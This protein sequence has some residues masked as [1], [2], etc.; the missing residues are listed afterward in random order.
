MLKELW[1]SARSLAWTPGPSLALLLTIG[2]GVG[3]NASIDGF[4]RGLTTVDLP[5][6]DL[7]TLV[8]L[9]SLDAHHSAGPL[10]FDD[11]LS[12]DNPDAPFAQLGA[13]RESQQNVTL[14][15][16][17]VPM[18]VA[19]ITPDVAN[20]LGL[21]LDD[22]AAISAR[23]WEAEAGSV[24]VYDRTIRIGGAETQVKSVAPAWLDGLY[25]SRP[26]DVWVPLR[27]TTLHA[28][29]RHS[30]NFWVLARLRPG[31]SAE[32]AQSVVNANR[33]PNNTIA[34]LPYRRMT[35][36]VAEGLSR[37]ATLLRAAAGALFF[38]TCANVASFVLARASTR[39]RDTAVRVALGAGRVHLTRQLLSDSVVI[40]VAGGALGIII[41]LW[42]RDIVPWL[43]FVEDAER[44]VFAPDAA[45]ILI[46]S[47]AGIAM[48]IVCGLAPMFD[49]RADK[50][51]AVLQ[52]E[53]AGDSPRMRLFRDVLLSMQ[54]ACCCL[55]IVSTGLLIDGLRRALETREGRRL[56]EVV[57]VTPRAPAFVS[58]YETAD[59]G[60]KYFEQVE[61]AAA[62]VGDVMQTAWVGTLPGSR[63][64]WQSIRVEPPWLPLRDVVLNTEPFTARSLA[65]VKTPPVAGQMFGGFATEGCPSVVVDEQA[66]AAL[67]DDDAV[68]RI[69][70]D[71]SGQRNQIIGVV[72]PLENEQ[73][74]RRTPATVYYDGEQPGADRPS[75]SGALSRPRTADAG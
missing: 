20:L 69:V 42:T 32:Q 56:G 14:L 65:R 7:D 43:F 33:S 54:M 22:G 50:P 52:R 29:D 25:V 49:L 58:H 60:L 48:T 74:T 8:S 11:Y 75:R 31:I 17:T 71:E 39:S 23:V 38:M 36:D 18:S 40:S 28:V 13:V 2:L 30:R 21:S 16:R 27:E 73:E 68:G 45:R 67:F 34:A 46:V 62:S 5:L 9:Y 12:L 66:A 61:R 10:S 44:L 59:K 41:A 57:L 72:A 4:S 6:Q 24:N 37:I 64:G 51:A 15:E 35:P 70:E 53:A 55:L 26:V 3:G 63:P 19:E 47:A 1:Y